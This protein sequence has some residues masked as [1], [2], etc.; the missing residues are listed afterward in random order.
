[1]P[2]NTLCPTALPFFDEYL[3][4]AEQGTTGGEFPRTATI[5]LQFTWSRASKKKAVF[6]DMFVG[7]ADSV[8]LTFFKARKEMEFQVSLLLSNRTWGCPPTP[9]NIFSSDTGP[10]SPKFPSPGLI[11]INVKTGKVRVKISGLPSVSAI[12]QHETMAQVSPFIPAKILYAVTGLDVL[13]IGLTKTL[14]LEAP[15]IKP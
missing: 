15:V 7:Y 12:A 4:H 3:A 13:G 11:I 9:P 1:M 2:L 10:F 8:K 5:G 6:D 14:A